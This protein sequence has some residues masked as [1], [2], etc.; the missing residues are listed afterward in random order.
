MVKKEKGTPKGGKGK[1][2]PANEDKTPAATPNNNKAKG[3]PPGKA[4]KKEEVCMLLF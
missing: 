1:K 2:A 3:R 4:K